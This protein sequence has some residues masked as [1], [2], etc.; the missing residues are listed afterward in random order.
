V[1]AAIEAS[2]RRRYFW[3]LYQG[4]WTRLYGS[5]SEADLALVGLLADFIGN[6]PEQIDR[7]FRKSK[8]YRDKWDELRGD[9]T[10]GEMT[11][12]KALGDEQ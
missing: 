6:N 11:I 5:Q 8:L 2:P 4:D 3:A 9:L 1:I 7:I 10:Y 12:N